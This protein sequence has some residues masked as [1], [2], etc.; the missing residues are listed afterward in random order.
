MANV[1]IPQNTEFLWDVVNNGGFHFLGLTSWNDPIPE[2]GNVYYAIGNHKA[3]TFYIN[4]RIRIKLIKN[5]VNHALPFASV[6]DKTRG[7]NIYYLN[8]FEYDPD[9]KQIYID[10][11]DY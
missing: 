7:T 6:K 1:P 10:I 8:E 2:Y 11:D 4:K 9:Q 5:Y 3:P